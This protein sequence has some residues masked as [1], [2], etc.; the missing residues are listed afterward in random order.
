[1]GMWLFLA[2]NHSVLYLISALLCYT[3]SSQ[4]KKKKSHLIWGE[5]DSWHRTATCR[6]S[7]YLLANQMP[8]LMNSLRQKEIGEI[9]ARLETA[10]VELKLWRQRSMCTSFISDICNVF[11]ML[12]S[13]TPLKT[14]LTAEGSVSCRCHSRCTEWRSFHR[15]PFSF[16]L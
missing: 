8:A 4:Q 9:K 1:M 12:Q 11:K 10:D 16:S 14:G 13:S 15:W 7:Q 5:G 6:N 2:H 3:L